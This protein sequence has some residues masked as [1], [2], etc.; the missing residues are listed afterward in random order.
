MRDPRVRLALVLC[1]GVL[2]VCL[3]RPGSLGLLTGVCA[4]PLLALRPSRR[5]WGRGLLLIGALIWGTVLSQGLFYAEQPRVALVS[6]GP[7]HFWR[8]GAVYGLA[9]SLRF[10]ALALAGLGLALSTP[11]DRM[12]AALLG[13]RLPFGLALM[14]STALRFLPEIGQEMA[15]VRRARAWRGRP[16]HHRSPWAW[17]R[18]EVSLLRPVLARSWRRAHTLAESLDTRG[19]DPLAPRAVRRPLRMTGGDW[20]ALVAALGL[21]LGVAGARGMY[22]L[23][24][25]DLLYVPAMRGLYGWVRA[26]L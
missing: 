23:Y 2:A 5:W 21:T 6:L 26:W 20:G 17:L 3:E 7:L 12:Y 1:A 22:L 25:A 4:L 11:P 15:T 9:Q 14:T 24:T 10:V 13:L 8:E 16:A 19:F 18:L